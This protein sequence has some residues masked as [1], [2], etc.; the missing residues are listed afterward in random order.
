MSDERFKVT[1]EQ[2]A[3]GIA[4]VLP[5][6]KFLRIN[7]KFCDIVGYTKKEMQSRTF[8]KITH[9]D[10]LDT[11]LEFMQQVLDGEI[12]TYSMEKRYLRKNHEIV[13]INLT[14]SLLCE[15]TGEP[16]YFI[17]VVQDITERKEAEEKLQKNT[18][19]QQLVSKISN[20]FVGLSGVELHQSIQDTFAEVGKYF[21]VDAVR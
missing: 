15:D 13:W 17:A 8:Q 3:V 19:F 5:D 18:K 10:D 16:S 6:G 4:H 12:E 2:A 20:E 11:D 14:V 7:Q 21:E 1:F 9:P